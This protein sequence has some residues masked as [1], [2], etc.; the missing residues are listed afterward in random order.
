[1]KNPRRNILF[2]DDVKDY[3]RLERGKS[4][5]NYTVHEQLHP[6][7]VFTYTSL[8]DLDTV[9][10]SRIYVRRGGQII[11][12]QGNVQ[13]A[14]GSTMSWTLLKNG[15]AVLATAGTI[16]AGSLVSPLIEWVDNGYF[17]PGDY[18]QFQV[19]TVGGAGGPFIVTGEFIPADL[20]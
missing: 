2:P 14:P 5:F 11:N 19:T 6:P 16:A 7:R 3:F 8:T 1:M 20:Y 12:L 18:F 9:A 15:T 10:G 4:D 13:T 17:V